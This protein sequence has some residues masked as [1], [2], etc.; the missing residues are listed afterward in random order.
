MGRNTAPAIALAALVNDESP[1]LLVLAADHVIQD[2]TGF[3]KA[4]IKRFLWPRLES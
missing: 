1:L 2:E 3:K 4:V